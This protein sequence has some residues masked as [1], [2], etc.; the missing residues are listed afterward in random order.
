MAR[1]SPFELPSYAELV[2]I[3]GK[4]AERV[5]PEEKLAIHFSDFATIV[6]LLRYFNIEDRFFAADLKFDDLAD[7]A[8]FASVTSMFTT[9]A[10]RIASSDTSD[11]ERILFNDAYDYLAE[12]DELA[13]ADVIFVFGL[14][15]T[16]RVEKAIRLYRERIAPKILISGRCPF[17]EIGRDGLPEAETL[18]NFAR[19][20][21]V[22]NE[23][24]ILESDSI[25]VPDNVK[26]SLN[27]LEQGSIAR[28]RIVLVNSPCA[29]RRG[30]AHFSKFSQQGTELIRVNVDK[31]SEQF[32]KAG[33]Y[34]SEAGV[35]LILKEFFG[36]RLST[37]I[38]SA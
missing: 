3:L 34:H 19:E 18:A 30:W 32:S 17:Y 13:P 14:K 22:P 21:G 5:V 38:N 15:T 26:R 9:L 6:A 12:E 23:A 29:Q 24:L 2:A 16:F 27:L 1:T 35:K 31:V 7:G 4:E 20:Q 28:C 33:W 37:I 36:L 11:T 10:D 8:I 25:T